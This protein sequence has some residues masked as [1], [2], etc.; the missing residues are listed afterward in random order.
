MGPH[1]S[2]DA[3]QLLAQ[4]EQVLLG[5]AADLLK[6]RNTFIDGKNAIPSLPFHGAES[7][8]QC[9]PPWS[10][11]LGISA[12][13]WQTPSDGISPGKRQTSGL[14]FARNRHYETLL[15]SRPQSYHGRYQDAP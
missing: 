11:I 5:R 1:F 13:T 2:N 3:P 12:T 15:G 9:G 4:D 6:G 10:S 7:L 8:S 14:N